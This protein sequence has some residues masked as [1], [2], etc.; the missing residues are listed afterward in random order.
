MAWEP[1]LFPG[2]AP[3]PES[4]EGVANAEVPFAASGM[5]PEFGFAQAV[6]SFH[7]GTNF[8][9]LFLIRSLCLVAGPEDGVPGDQQ[10]VNGWHET[11][12]DCKMDV[13]NL[14]PTRAPTTKPHNIRPGNLR[15]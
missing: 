15:S 8:R 13:R 4:Q 9:I 10:L 11:D 14:P 7:S 2:P 1:F 3:S 6:S 12:L 5:L